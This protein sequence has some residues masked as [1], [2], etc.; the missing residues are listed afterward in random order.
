MEGI[1]KYKS[2]H[3]M[4]S[5]HEEFDMC[6]S[7][8]EKEFQ[9]LKEDMEFIAKC[10]YDQRDLHWMVALNDF[11][12]NLY[13]QDTWTKDEIVELL[14]NAVKPLSVSPYLDYRKDAKHGQ[15]N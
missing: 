3:I 11:K 13:R 12:L 15:I 9:R 14:S 2:G 10:A 4:G 8:F 5:E 1:N 7:P 6:F